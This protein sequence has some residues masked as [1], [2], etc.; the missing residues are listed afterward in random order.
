MAEI[1]LCVLDDIQMGSAK[2]FEIQDE[3]RMPRSLFVVHDTNNKYYAY[4]NSCPH[5]SSPLDWMP[6]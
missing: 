5:T 3:E 4:R 6:N 1:F 2:G